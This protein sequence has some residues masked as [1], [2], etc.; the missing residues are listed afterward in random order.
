MIFKTVNSVAVKSYHIEYIVLKI[1]RYIVI[2]YQFHY[3]HYDLWN[4][5]N[6][7]S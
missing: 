7:S 4:I 2:Q 1:K 3:R 6:T 5:H